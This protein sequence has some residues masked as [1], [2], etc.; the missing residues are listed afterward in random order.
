MRLVYLTHLK[1]LIDSQH[2][3]QH[4]I[5]MKMEM[6]MRP[7]IKQHDDDDLIIHWIDLIAFLAVMNYMNLSTCCYSSLNRLIT[8]LQTSTRKKPKMN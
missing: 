4:L 5:V 7:Q 8:F 2:R 3:H 1:D 6:I